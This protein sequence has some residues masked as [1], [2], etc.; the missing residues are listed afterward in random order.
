M[1]NCPKCRMETR[2]DAEWCWHCGYAYEDGRP[3]PAIEGEPGAADVVLT[4]D[5]QPREGTT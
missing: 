4:S 5:E 2:R 1:K 3:D